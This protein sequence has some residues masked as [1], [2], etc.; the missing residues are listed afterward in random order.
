MFKCQI[1]DRIKKKGQLY[2]VRYFLRN[3]AGEFLSHIERQSGQNLK[4][5][6]ILAVEI[7]GRQRAFKIA[8]GTMS[9][10]N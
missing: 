9:I 4:Y 3:A 5:E 1:K 10:I 2:K 6:I 7:L 8:A